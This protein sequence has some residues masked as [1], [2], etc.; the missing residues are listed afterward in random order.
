MNKNEPVSMEMQLSVIDGLCLAFESGPMTKEETKKIMSDIYTTAHI[1]GTCEN[2][3]W[4]WHKKCRNL[5]RGLKRHGFC[6][7]VGKMRMD[8]DKEKL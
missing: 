2:P 3:H 4:V 1:N 6:G 7:G 5:Y 8:K